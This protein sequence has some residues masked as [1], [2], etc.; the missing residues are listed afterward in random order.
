[1]FH[2]A[3]AQ[4]RRCWW[5][6]YESEGWDALE[7]TKVSLNLRSFS[8]WG[9]SIC[10]RQLSSPPC[11]VSIAFIFKQRHRQCEEG[12]M[13]CILLSP[14]QILLGIKTKV[15]S[16]VLF[17]CL[18]I[19]CKQALWSDLLSFFLNNYVL[20]KYFMTLCS[21]SRS[22]WMVS[23]A[24]AEHLKSQVYES[25]S[26]FKICKRKVRM[27]RAQHKLAYVVLNFD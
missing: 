11:H 1:M 19:L 12:S 21:C 14:Y 10:S 4:W 23:R 26:C 15:F 20:N 2:S 13:S 9:F 8:C 5:W 3:I 25:G 27:R 22:W 18:C 24:A 17:Y 6:C 16:W 7:F